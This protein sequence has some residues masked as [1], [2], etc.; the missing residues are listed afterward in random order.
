MLGEEPEIAWRGA[1]MPGLTTEGRGRITANYLGG[2][3]RL[4]EKDSVV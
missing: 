2:G 1:F 4:P 3:G